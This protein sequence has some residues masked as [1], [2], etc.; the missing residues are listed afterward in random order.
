MAWILICKCCNFG[1]KICYNYR[2]VEFF[3]GDY[4]LLACPVYPLMYILWFISSGHS[5]CLVSH[6]IVQFHITHM[7]IMI[8]ISKFFS[9]K[10]EFIIYLL[11]RFWCCRG[12]YANGSGFPAFLTSP[13]AFCTNIQDIF[14]QNARQNKF[15]EQVSDVCPL[16]SSKQ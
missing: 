4:F 11:L 2:D 8:L 3:L 10:Y 6:K 13:P 9:G 14:Q 12:T 1:G 16:T 5:L 15:R 7:C